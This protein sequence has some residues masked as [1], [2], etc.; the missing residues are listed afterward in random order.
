MNKQIDPFDELLSRTIKRLSSEQLEEIISLALG[1]AVDREYVATVRHIDFYPAD[2][3]M[4][5]VTDTTDILIRIKR[6]HIENGLY[7][8]DEDLNE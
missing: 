6:K 4:A 2:T 3:N 5:D 8:D 7:S 1:K